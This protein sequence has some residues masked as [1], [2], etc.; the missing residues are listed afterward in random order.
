[1][2]FKTQVLYGSLLHKYIDQ[3]HLH[4]YFFVLAFVLF[5]VWLIDCFLSITYWHECM[6]EKIVFEAKTEIED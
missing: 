6:G 1:M 4:L 2:V 3:P 5:F